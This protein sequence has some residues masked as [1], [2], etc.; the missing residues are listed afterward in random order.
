MT[1]ALLA[2]TA[3]RI[4]RRARDRQRPRTVA[5]EEWPDER[6]TRAPSTAPADTAPEIP[7]HDQPNSLVIG[8]MRMESVVT[9]AGLAH[10]VRAH[11]AAHRTHP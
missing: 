8:T 1:L 4:R 9:A 7:A 11:R 6:A 3:D 2:R 5:V 10:D